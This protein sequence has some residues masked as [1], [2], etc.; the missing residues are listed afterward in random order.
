MDQYTKIEQKL[1]EKIK[2]RQPVL[3]KWVADYQSCTSKEDKI[4]SNAFD[5]MVE[6]IAWLLHLLE[7]ANSNGKVKGRSR[8]ST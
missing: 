8:K 2:K 3:E 7:R 1:L 5:D 4:A 6:D